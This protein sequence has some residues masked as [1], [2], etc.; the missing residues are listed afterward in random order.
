M[1]FEGTLAAL[2]TQLRSGQISDAHLEQQVQDLLE[3]ERA[4]L[5]A[6][7]PAPQVPP[8]SRPTP[9]DEAKARLADQAQRY[10]EFQ[11]QRARLY[12]DNHRR[13]VEALTRRRKLMKDTWS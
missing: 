4:R 13:F 1:D 12:A 11:E 2:Y 9:A 6:A 5:L 10:V 3:R 8:G 7:Y